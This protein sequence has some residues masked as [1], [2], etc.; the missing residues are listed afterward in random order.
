[1]G[2]E[3]M[4]WEQMA[5]SKHVVPIT[6]FWQCIFSH[7]SQGSSQT[8]ENKIVMKLVLIE[9][10]FM[11]IVHWGVFLYLGLLGVGINLEACLGF[12]RVFVECT[13]PP[14]M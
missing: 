11:Q 1:M 3:H 7:L 8:K 14:L 4:G 9:D 6:L 13:P 12:V 2:K 5:A 10:I